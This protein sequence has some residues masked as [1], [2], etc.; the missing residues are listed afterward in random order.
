MQFRGNW[1]VAHP[2]YLYVEDVKALAREHRLRVID[3]NAIPEDERTNEVDDAPALTLR[4]AGQAAQDAPTDSNNTA[5]EAL[6][7]G[8]RK[9]K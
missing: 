1:Y 6:E 3:A 7:T 2:T 4:D 9:G 8:K 5:P